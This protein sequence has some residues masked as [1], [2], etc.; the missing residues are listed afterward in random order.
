MPMELW[1]EGQARAAVDLANASGAK[2]GKNEVF[3]QSVADKRD[4]GKNMPFVQAVSARDLDGDG[5]IN[6]EVRPAASSATKRALLSVLWVFKDLPPENEI[7]SGV[8]DIQGAGLFL[9]GRGSQASQVWGR[10]RL[11][12]TKAGAS[13][14]RPM[15]RSIVTGPNPCVRRTPASSTLKRPRASRSCSAT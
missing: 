1:V 7:I 14:I 9:A 11:R 10:L 13:C 12:R 8:G 6:L 2:S 15:A 4:A 3:I 5:W